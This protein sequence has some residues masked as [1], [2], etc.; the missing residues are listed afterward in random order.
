MQKFTRSGKLNE[1]IFLLLAAT[2]TVCV[3]F[4]IVLKSRFDL[5]VGNLGDSRFL[6]VTLENWYQSAIGNS[7]WINPPYFFPETG[8]LGYSDAL[9]LYVP[10]YVLFRSVGA[11]PLLAF[12]INVL[13]LY[14]VAFIAMYL[15]A[16]GFGNNRSVSLGIAAIATFSN[17]YILA[18]GHAQLTSGL[19]VILLILL[20]QRAK[21]QTNLYLSHA[22]FAICGLFLG[23]LFFTS[24][25]IAWYVVFM[26]TIYA[27]LSLLISYRLTILVIKKNFTNTIYFLFGMTIGLIPFLGTYLPMLSKSS[28][29]SFEEVSSYVMFPMDLVNVGPENLIWGIFANISN[30][31]EFKHLGN[32]EFM[33]SPTLIFS[34]ITITFCALV[35]KV[36]RAPLTAALTAVISCGLAF[37][38]GDFVPWY[39]VFENI[40]GAEAIRAIGRIGLVSQVF[41]LVAMAA[42]LPHL[43]ESKRKPRLNFAIVLAL[44]LV[45]IEQL[46]FGLD[47]S[48]SRKDLMAWPEVPPPPKQCQSF[49]V[50]PV[51][52]RPGFAANLDAMIIAVE[53]G[54]PTANGYS[55][56]FPE[57]WRLLDTQSESYSGEVF[58]WTAYS[59]TQTGLCGF[60]FATNKWNVSPLN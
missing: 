58:K 12:Q 56:Y 40:P 19:L 49:F 50:D 60:D 31:L 6:T 18:A 23:L 33:M 29:R 59:G 51:E 21:A 44:V 35:F 15:V 42:S 13:L 5:V 45:F 54:V 16:K 7:S 30:G 11:E 24:F 8:V 55:G 10:T 2:S 22:L 27:F 1:T 17:N 41:L 47:L 48:L 32:S 37:K 34:L 46:N 4:I 43:P 3:I 14:F 53:G 20:V 9:F 38:Y 28:G 26:G 36:K 57:G 52:N 25:Y 39:F